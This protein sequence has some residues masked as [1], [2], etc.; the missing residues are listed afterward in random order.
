MSFE[1][2]AKRS[3]IA[4]SKAQKAVGQIPPDLASRVTALEQSETDFNTRVGS[5]ED[6]ISSGYSGSIVVITG[7]NFT[8]QSTTTKTITI[9][10][11]VITG[12]A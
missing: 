12:V 9:T 8:A 11:G 5:I 4:I 3:K 7:V 10:D 6:L 1:R 2:S